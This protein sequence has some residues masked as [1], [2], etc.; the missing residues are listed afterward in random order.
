MTSGV[1]VGSTFCKV[2]PSTASA[3]RLK[4]YL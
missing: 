2:F 4:R 3:L 1:A